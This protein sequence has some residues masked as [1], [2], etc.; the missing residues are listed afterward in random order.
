MQKLNCYN[1]L[2]ADVFAACLSGLVMAADTPSVTAQDQTNDVM[3]AGRQAV[4]NKNWTQAIAS[5]KKAVA[6][7][8]KNADAYN[9]LGYS[10][11][12]QGKFDDAFTA[13]DKALAIEPQHK[14]A[15]EYSGLGYLKTNQ[16]VKAEA[17]LAKLKAI[18]ATCEE[19]SSLTK[20]LADYKPGIVSSTY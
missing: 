19:T 20:A 3:A 2:I 8:P 16:K 1:I 6:E 4:Q 17:Q 13:Y 9:L 5:F 11:R 18:C 7:N 15:L 14:G 12:A 10:H